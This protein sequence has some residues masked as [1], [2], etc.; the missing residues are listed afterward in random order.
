MSSNVK[1]SQAKQSQAKDAK[2]SKAKHR[3]AIQSETCFFS[4]QHMAW[5]ALIFYRVRGCSC[6]SP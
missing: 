3:Q 6:F 5:K 2:P 4:M 1:K